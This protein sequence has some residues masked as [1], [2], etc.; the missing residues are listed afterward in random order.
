MHRIVNASAE[1]KKKKTVHNFSGEW[2]LNSVVLKDKLATVSKFQV[3]CRS[4]GGTPSKRFVFP[5]SVTDCRHV[6][7]RFWGR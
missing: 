2:H 6:Y 4:L 3:M 1:A 5:N 7:V